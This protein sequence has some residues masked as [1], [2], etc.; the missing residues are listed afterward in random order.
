MAVKWGT[1][2]TGVIGGWRND[3]RGFSVG[4]EVVSGRWVAG[5]WGIGRRV[6]N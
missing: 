1:G 5:P 6:G 3:N 2:R 4:W